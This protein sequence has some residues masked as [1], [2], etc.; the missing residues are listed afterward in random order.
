MIRLQIQELSTGYR[1]PKG[2]QPVIPLQSDLNLQV[3]SGQILGV[4][5]P[6]GAGKSTLLATIAGLVPPVRG[7]IFVDAIDV[8]DLPVHQRRI[9]MVFQEPALF[10]HLDV[11][12]NVAYGPRRQGLRKGAARK[13]ASELLAWVGLQHL[14][15]RSVRTLS[16]GQAQRVALVRALAADP[17]VLLLDEPFS[18]LDAPLRQRLGDELAQ[19]VRERGVAAL[20]VTHDPDEAL[21]I[22]DVLLELD[23]LNELDQPGEHS[24]PSQHG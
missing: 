22:C 5:A 20:H 15:H 8:T 4:T 11:L 16:G 21:R 24:P 13:R 2:H 9:A 12:D 14:A 17:A 10:G 7:R 18:A 3:G 1:S 6:S 19:I 23:Q